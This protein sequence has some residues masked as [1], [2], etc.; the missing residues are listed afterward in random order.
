M[1]TIKNYYYLHSPYVKNILFQKTLSIKSN[2]LNAKDN[3]VNTYTNLKNEI[4][5]KPN[6]LK[7]FN[8]S[9]NLSNIRKIRNSNY[10]LLNPHPFNISQKKNHI[11]LFYILY[12]II[13]FIAVLKYV[14]Y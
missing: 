4:Y 5:E 8:N 12:F 6:I 13:F 7:P 3:L 1:N 11:L 9:L 10:S 14:N 2:L